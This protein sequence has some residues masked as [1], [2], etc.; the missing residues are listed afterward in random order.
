MFGTEY[1]SDARACLAIPD[2]AASGRDTARPANLGA[3]GQRRANREEVARER[4]AKDIRQIIPDSVAIQSVGK[5][6]LRTAIVQAILGPGD[7]QSD[8]TRGRIV[9][10]GLRVGSARFD[11][12]TRT[13]G[14]AHGPEVDGS[15]A[16]VH[17]FGVANGIGERGQSGH[18][19]NGGGGETHRG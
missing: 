12:L 1:Q 6:G 10:Y 8:T 13:N 19:G 11:G 5:V 18:R 16:S 9:V 14:A 15:V 2:L 7:L 17:D 3:S 4:I